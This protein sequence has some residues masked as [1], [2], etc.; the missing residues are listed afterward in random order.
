MRND[1]TQKPNV[2]SISPGKIPYKCQLWPLGVM[3][4]TAREFLGF[5]VFQSEDNLTGNT[6]QNLA[7]NLLLLLLSQ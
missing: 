7:L 2:R 5:G 1:D 4:P 6:Q 3:V